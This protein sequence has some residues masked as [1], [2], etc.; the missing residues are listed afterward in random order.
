MAPLIEAVKALYYKIT[1]IER[2]VDRTVAEVDALKAENTE[3]KQRLD[4][5]EKMM[6]KQQNSK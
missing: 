1:G 6:F 3:L 2:K 4:R 5:L